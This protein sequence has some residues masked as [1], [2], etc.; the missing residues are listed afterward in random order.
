MQQVFKSLSNNICQL[1]RNSMQSADYDTKNTETPVRLTVIIW[2]CF[3]G[4]DWIKYFSFPI[5]VQKKHFV[6]LW[7]NRHSLTHSNHLELNSNLIWFES[8]LI[9]NHLKYNAIWQI[10][11][12]LPMLILT[13]H[14]ICLMWILNRPYINP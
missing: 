6:I 1:S 9:W 10:Y 5:E 3:I 14:H 7:S 8:N 4:A 11:L 13:Y 2:N 12:L